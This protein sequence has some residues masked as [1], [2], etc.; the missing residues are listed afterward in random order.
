MMPPPAG[1]Q[2]PDAQLYPSPSYPSPSSRSVDCDLCE[3]TVALHTF[4]DDQHLHDERIVKAIEPK[5]PCTPLSPADVETP[6]HLH[7]LVHTRRVLGEPSRAEEHRELCSADLFDA[8]LSSG[9]ALTGGDLLQGYAREPTPVQPG[10]I[11][12]GLAPLLQV[13]VLHLT[14]AA[15]R[16]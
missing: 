16:A 4:R 14:V 5:C 2:T 12:H 8:V 10:R 11:A 1:F 9:G 7:G 3:L 6:S 13:C 15:S